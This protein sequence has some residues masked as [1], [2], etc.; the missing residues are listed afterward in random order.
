MVAGN[1][2][3][4]DDQALSPSISPDGSRIAYTS[5]KHDRWWAP[6]R[7]DYKWEI[8]TSAPDGSDRRRLTRSYDIGIMNFNPAWSPDGTRIAFVSNR[9]GHWAVYTMAADGL[10]TRGVAPSVVAD[11]Q[12]PVWSPN[13]Q[14]LAF[15]ERKP[16]SGTIIRRGLYTVGADGSSLKRI[17]G[18]G[19]PLYAESVPA[20]SP[21]GSRIAFV[22][23]DDEMRA[24]LATDPDGSNPSVVFDYTNIPRLD[25]LPLQYISWSPDGSKILFSAYGTYVG[26]VSANDTHA[27]L[28]ADLRYGVEGISLSP[29]GSSV[30][31]RLHPRLEKTP[32]GVNFDVALFTM[33]AD[34]TNKRVMARYEHGPDGTGK[35]VP[36]NGRSWHAEYEQLPYPELKPHYFGPP[37][38]PPPAQTDQKPQQDSRE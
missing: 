9:D 15:L 12:G 24:I 29:D 11:W 37:P 32:S 23:H 22:R 27:R 19:S 28:L 36:A 5:F 4:R 8:V 18:W 20:W 1:P 26:V 17:E 21:D 7:T 30:T 31:V 10:D 35:V 34:G 2:L 13:G 14:F 6:W 3:D 25:S 16:E 38:L 33:N